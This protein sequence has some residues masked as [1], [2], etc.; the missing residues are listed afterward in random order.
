[1]ADV[2]FI[3][4]ECHKPTVPEMG[5]LPFCIHETGSVATRNTKP[6]VP[7]FTGFIKK[8]PAKAHAKIPVIRGK[9]DA[10]H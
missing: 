7:H 10:P 2:Q 6:N 8:A 5:D 3:M 4:I 1:M 9:T